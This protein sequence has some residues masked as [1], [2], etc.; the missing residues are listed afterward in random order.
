MRADPFLVTI[1]KWVCWS[2][3]AGVGISNI[4]G[5]R[6]PGFMMR[7]WTLCGIFF[8]ISVYLYFAA[9]PLV[10]YSLLPA[11]IVF[12][13]AS[14]QYRFDT[15]NPDHVI[16]L[17]DTDRWARTS[18]RGVIDRAPD[19]RDWITHIVIRPLE[20]DQG[21]GYRELTGR[22]GNIIIF[23]SQDIRAENPYYDTMDYGDIVRVTGAITEPMRR[24]NPYGFDY[25]EYLMNQNI[26][27]SM[28]V[29][30]PENIE[31]LERSDLGIFGRVKSFAFNLK[32]RMI[33]GLKKTV[34]PPYSA[35]IGGVTV[36]ARGGVPE[37]MRYDFQATG[38][39]HVLALS[40]LHVGFLALMLI[41][42][43][44]TFFKS[45]LLFYEIPS[46]IFRTEVDLTPHSLKLIPVFV[47][48]A[49]A[50]F[51]IIT[52]ARPATI[53]AAMMYSIMIVISSWFGMTLSRSGGLTIPMSAAVMLAFNSFLI[54]DAS[55]ALS[56]TAVWSIIYLNAPIRRMFTSIISGWGQAAFFLFV[57]LAISV[58]VVTP[59]LI[60]NPVFIQI[61]LLFMALLFGAA[62]LLERKFPLTGFNFEAWWPGISG[63]F[64]AQLA[65]QIG[66]MW[67][68][69]GVYF[70]RF[71][72]AGVLANFIAIPLIGIIVPL[73]LIGQLFTF[74][75]VA[76]ESLGLAMGATNMLFSRF[77]LWMARFFRTY[78]PYPV[79]SAPTGRWLMIYYTLVIIFAFN[80]DI[81]LFLRKR[82]KIT[83]KGANWAVGGIMLLILSSGY[84]ARGITVGGHRDP[85]ETLI[86]FFDVGFGNSV[87]IQAPSGKSILIDGGNRGDRR[88][89]TMGRFSSGEAVI[90]PNLSGY[91]IPA[92]DIMISSNP[93]PENLGGLVYLSEHFNVRSAWSSLDPERFRRGIGYEEFLL[94][95]GD[96]R[97]EAD[98][99]SP[100]PIGVYL[101][102][103]DYLNTGLLPY[104]DMV[105]MT[106][107]QRLLS[108][109]T[110]P[111]RHLVEGT[112]IHRE[113]APGGVFLLEALG[114]PEERYRGTDSD[115]RNNSAVLRLTY[116]TRVFLFTSGIQS[117][118][119]WDLAERY[120][121][122]LRADVLLV[123][124]HGST[125]ASTRRLVET[126]SP[127]Y[128]IVQYGYLR[129]RSFHDSQIRR[130]Q[131]RYEERGAKVLRTDK[132]G[133]VEIR[134]DGST[135]K[136]NT[137][138]KEM[139]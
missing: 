73:G 38:V 67:P 108:R 120:G 43:F 23:V 60:Y 115:I 95:L 21:S 19:V 87:M 83:R 51:V 84:W 104:S 94:N 88:W 123:P 103:Y 14:Y 11:F 4:I 111:H 42:L 112:V 98:S 122:G 90:I 70:N 129:G 82:L 13:I 46:K 22:T 35:F 28:Y 132:A 89:W 57:I 53:R 124:D 101:N 99:T 47:V 134:T 17:R 52:G 20:I 26:Y 135:L 68:L 36:G 85:E 125:S 114:P 54:F 12:G 72:I 29:G 32:D 64:C 31:F 139:N 131:G 58:L 119:E 65:I 105:E 66:M 79:Q 33:L 71:P 27:A 2:F 69:S 56:F 62:Y 15:T 92:L 37:A 106:P 76:G 138:L 100:L 61:F 110:V 133:A 10:K 25:A 113:E 86:T 137:V 96:L 24:S 93:L 136:V 5:P 41:M 6:D 55:F 48:G 121:D 40:G 9:R 80:S 107:V 118:A 39:A 130:T 49:L 102:F 16:H 117:E 44:N 1:I 7:M 77:F 91:H 18:V 3:V 128:A 45:R 116:G 63:F 81:R 127:S 75:P 97:L 30:E 109:D 126:V 8:A 78:F 59:W 74:I 50:V 34:P